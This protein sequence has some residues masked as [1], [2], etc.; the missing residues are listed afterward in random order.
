MTPASVQVLLFCLVMATMLLI[1]VAVPLAI[2]PM[3]FPAVL[4]SKIR[5]FVWVPL[6]GR[7]PVSVAMLTLTPLGIK[8][9]VLLLPTPVVPMVET[10][11]ATVLV[12][13]R[14]KV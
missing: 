11:N 1:F 3:V 8:V 9:V 2:A 13:V 10:P 7:A 12:E 6:V 4:P 14:F 5:V